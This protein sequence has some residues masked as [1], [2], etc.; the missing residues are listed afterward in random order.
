MKWVL[1]EDDLNSEKIEVNRI[2]T[3]CVVNG[4]IAVNQPGISTSVIANART[5]EPVCIVRI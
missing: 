1:D 5:N 4:P 3:R 2:K